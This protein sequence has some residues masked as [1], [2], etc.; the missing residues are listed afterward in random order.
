MVEVRHNDEALWERNEKAVDSVKDRLRRV[1]EALDHAQIPDAVIEDNAVQYWVAQVDRSVVRNIQ[2][3]NILLNRSDLPRAT[4]VLEAAGLID[5]HADH[6]T[7]FLDGPNA[8][9][10]DAVYLIFS[11]EKVR[12]AD[13]Y[14][15][16]EINDATWF[17]S[18]R[19]IPLKSLVNMK[20]TSFRRKDQVHLLNMMSIGLIDATWCSQLPE[21]LSQRLQQLLDD[22]DG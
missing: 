1:C 10:R 22:P 19:T 15:A 14:A 21:E 7:M 11:G 13:A 9:A 4:Q 12:K 20:L 2:D 17:E 8:G 16:S 5:R 6:I 18:D 3:V